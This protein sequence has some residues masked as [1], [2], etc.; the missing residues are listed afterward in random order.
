MNCPNC[1]AE[2]KPNSRFCT[3]CGATINQAS[4][5]PAQAMTDKTIAIAP[6]PSPDQGKTQAV[7]PVQLPNHYQNQG[8]ASPNLPAQPPYQQP[9]QAPPAQQSYQPQQPYQPQYQQQPYVPMGYNVPNHHI[10]A[11]PN[12]GK[13]PAILLVV[14]ALTMLISI[15][16]PFFTA[17]GTTVSLVEV[18]G[19][20]DSADLAEEVGAA[21]ILIGFPV[22]AVLGVLF[23]GM[24]LLK[25]RT[26][27]GV[28]A[29]LLGL[30]AFGFSGLLLI[31]INV[32]NSAGD[33]SEMGLW[34]FFAG[35]M[36]MFATSIAYL[37]SKR[38]PR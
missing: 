25:R 17:D 5:A 18:L 7:A 16:L 28:L 3:N 30:I 9:Y 38:L 32:S 31:G 33:R 26:M 35:A 8:Y 27:W 1:S 6:V 2:L 4:V 14:S 19:E 37:V 21:S 10:G 12:G 13:I 22:A 36:F 23:G 29:L 20:V 11:S 34:L 24:A 15:F